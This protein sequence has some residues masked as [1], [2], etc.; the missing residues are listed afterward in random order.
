MIISVCFLFP[1]HSSFYIVNPEALTNQPASPMCSWRATWT[2]R[3]TLWIFVV[4]CHLTSLDPQGKD[5]EC[6][7]FLPEADSRLTKPGQ[8]L[9]ISSDI[10]YLHCKDLESYFTNFPKISQKNPKKAKGIQHLPCG[11]CASG[12]PGLGCPANR[13]PPTKEI[14]PSSWMENA[15]GSTKRWCKKWEIPT[16]YSQL[17]MI[18]CLF[19]KHLS[20]NFQICKITSF[21]FR[22]MVGWC[23]PPGKVALRL[24]Q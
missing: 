5:H 11:T 21:S 12:F 13:T 3:W 22:K 1:F 16:D 4:S 2:K 10:S 24:D 18:G 6:W 9:V 19:V 17:C 7:V 14:P 15:S 20:I 8:I 23:S